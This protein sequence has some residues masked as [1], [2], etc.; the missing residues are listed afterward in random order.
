MNLT[1]ETAL[2]YLREHPILPDLDCSEDTE[3]ILREWTDVCEYFIEHPC[4]E[5]IPLFIS[6]LSG[7]TSFEG[8]QRITDII[9]QLPVEQI[10][11]LFIEALNSPSQNIRMWVADFAGDLESSNIELYETLLSRVED[12]DENDDDRGLSAASIH[13]LSRNGLIDWR[14][15]VDRINAILAKEKDELI[16]YSLTELI[17]GE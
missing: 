4:V 10:E 13:L 7:G 9:V 8:V 5:A 2:V 17:N 16:I 1:K 11:P 3:R 6:E 15:Y 14:P 12:F